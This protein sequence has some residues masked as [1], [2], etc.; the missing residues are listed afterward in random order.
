MTTLVD[1]VIGLLI[2]FL[3]VAWVILTA[4]AAFCSGFRGRMPARDD[5]VEP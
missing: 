5:E 1:F 2:G 3:A 4:A